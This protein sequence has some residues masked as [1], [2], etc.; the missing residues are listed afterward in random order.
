MVFAVLLAA[1]I[2][3]TSSIEIIC[4]YRLK[5]YKQLNIIYH[6]EAYNVIVL[7]PNS[8]VTNITGQ[9]FAQPVFDGYS[10]FKGFNNYHDIDV[11]GIYFEFSVVY[12]FPK[13]IEQKFKNLTAI[14]I[15]NSKLR[16]IHQ[17]DLKVFPELR[18][19]SLKGNEI[20][21]MEKDLF[22]FNPKLEVVSLNHN[23]IKHI[24]PSVF[25]GLKDIKVLQLALNP[26][27]YHSSNLEQPPQETIVNIQS[28]CK[29]RDDESS[30]WVK[31]EEGI[32][33]SIGAVCDKCQELTI[34]AYLFSVAFIVVLS[35][36]IIDKYYDRANRRY[37]REVLVMG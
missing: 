30:D 16:E 35:F 6:C 1:T 13:N 26:C 7:E 17:I 36:V 34:T 8:V 9:H 19:L 11:K 25:D 21:V 14:S 10:T 24:D 28:K 32:D 4:F 20:Q 27:L 15:I 2:H 3:L 31:Q 23:H 18:Y 33:E 5:F 37:N 29:P 12:Y 22:E